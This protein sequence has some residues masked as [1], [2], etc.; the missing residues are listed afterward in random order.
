[1]SLL[2]I[3]SSPRGERSVS[4]TLSGEFVTT[5]HR[6]HPAAPVVTRDIGRQPVPH[7]DEEWIAG[8][9]TPPETHSP[10]V[11]ERVRVSNALIDELLAAD[12]IVLG[13]PMYNFG[14][15]STLKAWLDQ[16]I[17]VG[18]TFT[19]DAG[20]N[21]QGLVQG[22]KLL[23]IASRGGSYR[24]GSPAAAYDMQEPYLR[25]AFGFMGITDVTFIYA[26]GLNLGDEARERAL[27]EAR[28]KLAD[29]A[30]HW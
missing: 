16:V 11:A 1:M 3:D 29:L 2:R 24:P 28:E 26:D 15:P 12:R 22:K 7:V 9:F 6:A 20:G 13:A 27:N 25:L 4:R 8:A 18:R 14:I 10:A 19:V 23:V 30:H 17:R 21:Y 5:W